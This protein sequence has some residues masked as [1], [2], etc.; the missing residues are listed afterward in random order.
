MQAGREGT[1]RMQ[2]SEQGQDSMRSLPTALALLMPLHEPWAP[3]H[4]PSL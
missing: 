4:L 1:V 3:W 2:A